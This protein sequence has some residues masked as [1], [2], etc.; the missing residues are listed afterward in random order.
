MLYFRRK[1]RLKMDA[2]S[3]ANEIKKRDAREEQAMEE[4]QKELTIRTSQ[5]NRVLAQV[6][7]KN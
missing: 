3:R 6:K 2:L 4:L 7:I 5:L 1:M